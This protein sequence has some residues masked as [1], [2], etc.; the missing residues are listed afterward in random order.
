[1]A[2]DYGNAYCGHCGA[3]RL[4]QKTL[5]RVCGAPFG[6]GDEHPP[7]TPPDALFT[8]TAVGTPAPLSRK[9]PPTGRRA[10]LFWFGAALIAVLLLLSGVGI[11]LLLA[12]HTPGGNASATG[13][14]AG[15][16]R[17]P[18]RTPSLCA[19]D[20]TSGVGLRLGVA[21]TVPERCVVV[22]NAVQGQIGGLTWK[23]GG[24]V[25]I[26]PGAY[27]G[28]ITDGIF[29]LFTAAEAEGRF[30]QIYKSDLAEGHTITFTKPLDG[31][32]DWMNAC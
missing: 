28:S 11:G 5:C 4:G 14:P 23:Q 7:G 8:S 24:V 10:S 6:P 1:M 22:I 19:G 13:Q 15:A 12:Q 26:P 9:Q 25:A 21:L 30:C 18:L 16:T 27:T 20:V 31:W 3:R 2:T 17:A 32:N 29:Q